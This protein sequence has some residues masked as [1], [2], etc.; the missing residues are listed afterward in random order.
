MLDQYGDFTRRD[1]VV[2]AVAQEDKDLKSHGK[3][4]KTLKGDVPFEI[5]ADIGLKQTGR[6]KRTTAYFI[7]KSGTVREVFPMII[8]SRPSWS[9][10]LGRIDELIE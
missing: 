10:I 8:H 3:M 5:V 4:H 1:T 6:Y 2:I 9:A 7:D